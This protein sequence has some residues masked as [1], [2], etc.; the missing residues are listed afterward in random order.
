MVYRPKQ[1]ELP[2]IQT[3]LS[4]YGMHASAEHLNRRDIALAARIEGELA[5]FLWVGLM[6]SNRA[7]YIDKFVVADR[8]RKQGVGNAL[9]LAALA[10]C[11]KRGVKEVHGFIRQDASHAASSMNAL[12]LALGADPHPY[13]YVRGQ[14]DF[15]EAELA[16]LNRSIA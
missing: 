2:E 15:I 9:A 14:I 3:L 13:T 10:E 6:A 7:A 4:N 16:S 12:K 5:G 11:K 1:H 8:W